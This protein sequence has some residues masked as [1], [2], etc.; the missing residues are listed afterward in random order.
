MRA[1]GE[2][3]P[4]SCRDRAACP[5]LCVSD[6]HDSPRKERAANYLE[7]HSA[8]TTGWSSVVSVEFKFEADNRLYSSPA[9]TKRDAIERTITAR[10]P[11]LAVRTRSRFS[12]SG[13][14]SRFVCSFRCKC[15]LPLVSFFLFL[16]LRKRTCGVVVRAWQICSGDRET[17]NADRP[18]AV[19]LLAKT[20]FSPFRRRLCSR[21]VTAAF[22]SYTQELFLF[23]FSYSFPK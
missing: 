16:P 11:A 9:T 5:A 13:I 7:T 17:D 20:T 12:R 3:A 10:N 4:C 23:F 2:T 15:G 14:S 6:V 18:G 21:T 19:H 8:R 1:L 22:S